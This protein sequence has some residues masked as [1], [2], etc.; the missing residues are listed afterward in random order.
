MAHS[1]SIICI[2]G[3]FFLRQSKP[4]MAVSYKHKFLLC[5][6]I[7]PYQILVCANDANKPPFEVA[8]PA[9]FILIA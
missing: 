5:C 8:R 7:I 4:E 1:L 2:S 6:Q 3:I 9:L